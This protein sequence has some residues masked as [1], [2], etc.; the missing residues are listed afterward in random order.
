V[1]GRAHQIGALP[2]RRGPGGLEILLVTSRETRRWV[3]PKGWPMTGRTDPEAAAIEAWEEAGVKGLIAPAPLGAYDYDKRLKDNS[4]RPCRVQVYAL[5][6][7]AD[8]ADWPESDE[9]DRCWMAP[10]EAIRAVQEPELKAL[11]EGFCQTS[12]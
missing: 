5:E 3:V 11:I 7:T 12:H 4:R 2:W 6:V 8:R 10:A 1:S 9:R